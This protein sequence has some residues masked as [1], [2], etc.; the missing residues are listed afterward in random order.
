VIIRRSGKDIGAETNEPDADARLVE[1]G[2]M[3]IEQ[4]VIDFYDLCSYNVQYC[5]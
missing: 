2:Y 1:G 3:E 4:P 5:R